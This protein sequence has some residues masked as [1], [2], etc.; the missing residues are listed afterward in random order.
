MA[1]FR[2]DGHIYKCTEGRLATR[3]SHLKYYVALFAPFSVG[4][5]RLPLLPSLSASSLICSGTA[6]KLISYMTL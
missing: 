1:G 6:V 3:T 5:G 4:T 2:R